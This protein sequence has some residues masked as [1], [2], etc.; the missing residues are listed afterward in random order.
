MLE[1]AGQQVH[2]KSSERMDEVPSGSVTLVLTSPPYWNVRDYGDV[3]QVGF[4]QSYDDYVAALNKI[5]VECIRVLQPNGKLAINVQPLPACTIAGFLYIL[6]MAR[7]M[8]NA[9]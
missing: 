2:F 9:E 3:Q 8:P 7:A 1:I 5:W 6:M 4:G